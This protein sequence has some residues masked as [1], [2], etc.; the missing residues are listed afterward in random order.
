MKRSVTG[1]L[2]GIFAAF[3]SWNTVHADSSTDWPCFRGAES[4]GIA[5]G[6]ATAVTWNATDA[7]DSSIQWKIP[8]PGLGHSCPTVVGDRVFLATAIATE[9]NVD[10]NVGRNGDIKAANDVGE[11]TWMILCFHKKDGKELWRSTAIRTVPK[12]TR[13]P[14][15]THAN[16]TLAVDGDQLVAFFGSEGLYCYDLD[17]NLRWKKDLGVIDISK[18]GIGWGYASSPSISQGKIV[19]VC[20]APNNPYIV[21][22][23]VSDGAEL[24]RKSRKEDCERSWGTPLIHATG[25]ST[26]VVINGWPWIV[27]YDGST[28]DERWRIRGG[29]DNPIPTPFVAKDRF[30]ITNSHGGKS[31]IY[32]IR[33]DASG[34]ISDANVG[35][36][37]IVWQSERGGSYMSTPIVVGNH[38]YLGDT[39]GVF[40]CF[41]AD[42]G[43]KVYE[44]RLDGG[45]YV[46]ASLVAADDKIYC[47]AEDGTIFV[48]QAGKDYKLLARNP[49][50]DSCHATPA[51]SKGVLY[52]RTAKSLFAIQA[53]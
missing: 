51:I 31:P 43:E 17:G 20:D 6:Y 7:N 15:A 9:D 29:G 41:D 27:S 1:Y 14:K 36:T 12:T 5:T 46:V 2:L 11:Q 21:A 25:E 33:P 30:Y 16:T 34:D 24:W 40:R 48:I 50:G 4:K 47:A 19:L 38:L 37:S 13:H 44:Q 35:S 23:R 45:A 8:I 22:L 49:M 39:T 18:Y 52:I 10:L 3:V 42:T 26:Q 53:K 28:G 32:A